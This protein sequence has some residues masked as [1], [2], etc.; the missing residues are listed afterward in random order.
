MFGHHM[1]Y[2]HVL[3]IYVFMYDYFFTLAVAP[4]SQQVGFPHML[5][6]AFLNAMSRRVGSFSL[7]T[8][9]A[10]IFITYTT[11]VPCVPPRLV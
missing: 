7:G 2:D 6:A 8:K 1:I 3:F 5:H 9:T 10:R 11:L 4:H